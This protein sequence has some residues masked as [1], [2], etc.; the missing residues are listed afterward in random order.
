MI[1]HVRSQTGQD[2]IFYI[3]HSMG[4]TGFYVMGSMRPEY[5]D[6]I[7]AMFSLAPIAYMS[8]MTSPLLQL[9]SQYITELQTGQDKIFYIGHSMGTTGFYVMG[10]MRPE[11]NDKIRAMFSLAP[12][13]Y[14]SHMTSPLL[15]LISQYITE[16]QDHPISKVEL[17]SSS[18]PQLGIPHPVLAQVASGHSVF[19]SNSVKRKDS[20]SLLEPPAKLIRR[21]NI[22]RDDVNRVRRNLTYSKRKH[23]PPLPKCAADVHEAIDS[24]QIKT[25]R[26]EVNPHSRGGRVENHLGKTT[27]VHPTETRTSIFPSSA[28][29]LNTTSVL[30]NYAT[31]ADG[32]ASSVVS[33][34]DVR[35]LMG[36]DFWYASYPCSLE[37]VGKTDLDAEETPVCH[38]HGSD[39]RL[40]R[41][42]KSEIQEWRN[43][44]EI[45]SK[46]KK[47]LE[48]ILRGLIGINEFSPNSE[49]LAE[50][51]Q[52]TC[53]DQAPTQ[54]VCGNVVFLFTGFDSQQ[55]NE[56]MLPVILG[57]TPAGSS[58]RQI[59]HYGQ[60]VKS[61]YFR[62][63]DHGSVENLFKY[64]SLEPPDYDLSKVTAPV[65]LHYSNNDWL[66]SI[67]DVDALYSELPNVIGMFLVPLD[68]FNHL[69]YMWAIDAKTLLYDTV[70]SMMNQY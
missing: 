47:M 22:R 7:R 1:D 38:L 9:I 36:F 43:P 64:G 33:S 68:Q 10:S 14:M 29:E 50:A 59:I 26:E 69:D 35:L 19:I 56:T 12:I 32:S 46:E 51:G 34:K 24:V 20:E 41:R 37:T 31:E 60:E 44:K 53:S 58:T 30:A 67:T 52:L 21:E 65:A 11:Y 8:H 4:T 63:Y 66:A 61:G 48:K 3:G 6:K 15:Q 27:P 13:A 5:N 55:L 39:M 70:I 28:V 49:F 62:Q 17:A 25:D 45:S 23:L 54:S 18:V 40:H 42:S 2:K 57:H 16:L